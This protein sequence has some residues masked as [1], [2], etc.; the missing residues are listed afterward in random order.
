MKGFSRNE[1]MKKEWKKKNE[2]SDLNLI[3]SMKE[4]IFER[5]RKQEKNSQIRLG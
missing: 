4:F 3:V 2:M 1:V 5:K